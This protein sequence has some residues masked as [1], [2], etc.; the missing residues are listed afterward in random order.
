MESVQVPQRS[1]RLSGSLRL[2]SG[3][4]LLVPRRSGILS[5]TVCESPVGAHTVF[6]P[7]QNVN[8]SRAGAPTVWETVWH[9]LAVSCRYQDGLGI[10]ADCLRVSCRC[11]GGLGYCL[12]QSGTILKPSKTVWECPAGVPP[13]HI[14]WE[15]PVGASP[16]L[17]TLWYRLRV[18][19]CLLQVP[20]WS[21]H[22]RRLFWS[23]LQV[24]SWSWSPSETV[25]DCLGLSYRCPDD[26]G[27]VEDCLGVS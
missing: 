25:T 12:A 2:V 6:P 17:K 11:P 21:W 7:S 20:R 14:V 22:R 3:S 16:V 5:G 9:H 23:L 18:S 24:P 13:S 27:T 15:F 8:E 10:V 26:L 19:G 1:G 4:L